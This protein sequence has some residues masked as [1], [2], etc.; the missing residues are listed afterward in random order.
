M[1]EI[2]PD[3]A[4]LIAQGQN[5]IKILEQNR[6]IHA[7]FRQKEFIILGKSTYAAMVL[8]QIFVDFY[9]C[10]ET[11]LFRVSQEFENNLRREHW[12]KELLQQMTLQIA[13]IRPAVL[14]EETFNFLNEILVFRHFRRYYFDY[15]YDWEKIEMIEKKYLTVFPLLTND[16]N[17]FMMFL[18]QTGN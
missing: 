9:T 11:F 10:L 15:H 18:K 13:E 12:H 6:K 14:S 5:T 8:S 7:D 3:F 16:L 1:K 17:H 2:N 4:V